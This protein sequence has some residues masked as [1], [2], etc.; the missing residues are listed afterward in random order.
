MD[1]ASAS[2]AGLI[3]T[4]SSKGVADLLYGFEFQVEL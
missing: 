1:S 4:L 3:F 2:T